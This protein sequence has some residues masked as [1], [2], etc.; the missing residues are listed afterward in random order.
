MKRRK[1]LQ[2]LVAGAAAGTLAKSAGSAHPIQ[3]HVDLA[4]PPAGGPYEA[5]Y[6]AG[7]YARKATF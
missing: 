4:N 6:R 1:Y 2:V 5:H 3:L 7:Y